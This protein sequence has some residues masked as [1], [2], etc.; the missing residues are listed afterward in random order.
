LIP[1]RQAKKYIDCF[2]P[3]VEDESFRKAYLGLYFASPSSVTTSFGLQLI[4]IDYNGKALFNT[5][6]W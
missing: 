1:D 2:E 6:G 3:S 5:P 4:V